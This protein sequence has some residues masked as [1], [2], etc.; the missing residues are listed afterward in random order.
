M[1]SHQ[2]RTGHR[3]RRDSWSP[4]LAPERRREDGARKAAGHDEKRVLRYMWALFRGGDGDVAKGDMALFAALQVDRPGRSF[5]AVEGAPGNAGNLLVVD[6]GLAVQDHG[7][8]AA[9]E[10]DVEGLPGVGG[11]GLL[12]SGR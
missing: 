5:V 7:D 8:A 11:S 1:N 10:G 4:T 9:D 2:V 3:A 12:G 6:H